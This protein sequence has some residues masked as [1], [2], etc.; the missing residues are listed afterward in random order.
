MRHS[1]IALA[2]LLLPLGGCYVEPAGYAQPGYPP[3][4]YPPPYGY[5]APAY[6]GGYDYNNGAPVIMEGGVAVPLVLLGGAWGYYDS[7]RRWH[8]APENVRR[9]LEQRRA[10]GA[11]LRPA[12][13]PGFQRPPPSGGNAGYR[14]AAAPPAPQRQEERDRRRDC[15]QPSQCR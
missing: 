11:P 5:P 7:E 3:P 13:A 12:A 14:P 2:A 9:D 6:P 4:A 8:G 15:Q 1:A 10:A